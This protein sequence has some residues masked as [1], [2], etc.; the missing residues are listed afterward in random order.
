[1]IRE[2]KEGGEAGS[3]AR[4]PRRDPAIVVGYFAPV[5]LALEAVPATSFIPDDIPANSQHRQTEP[6][7]FSLFSSNPVQSSSSVMHFILCRRC[8][9]M[10]AVSRCPGVVV[11]RRGRVV[12]VNNR[13]LLEVGSG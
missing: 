8:P 4:F 5:G 11:G 1:M 7:K 6:Q 2:E 12:V 13:G 9:A 3:L 10:S